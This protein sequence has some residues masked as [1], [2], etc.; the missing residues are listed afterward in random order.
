M[1]MNSQSYI[2]NLLSLFSMK[3]ELVLKLNFILNIEIEF[4]KIKNSFALFRFITN[5]INSYRFF[6][7]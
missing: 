6:L 5:L 2:Q 3:L 4:S 7:I 1:Y